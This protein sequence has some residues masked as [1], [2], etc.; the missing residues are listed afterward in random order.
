MEVDKLIS[1]TE[2]GRI[3]DKSAES[4]RAYER[5]GKLPALKTTRGMRLFRE[6]DVRAFAAK[7]QSEAALNHR[8]KP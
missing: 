7:Q 1:A 2:A 8:N 5:Q 4:V 3:L 6:C